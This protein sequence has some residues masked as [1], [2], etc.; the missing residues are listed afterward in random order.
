MCGHFT[1]P[2]GGTRTFLARNSR[3]DGSSCE[4]RLVSARSGVL[5]EF[6]AVLCFAPGD[7][8]DLPV[9]SGLRRL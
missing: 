9:I 8:G 4:E 3:W 2:G 6:R 5:W 1:E 7:E